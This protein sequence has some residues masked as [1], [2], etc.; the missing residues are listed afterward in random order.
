MNRSFLCLA[1]CRTRSS[2][3]DTLAR[4]SVRHVL[5]WAVFP[6]VP[7]LGSTP[8]ATG[9]PALFGSFPA[10][11]SEEVGLSPF[12]RPLAQTA[13]AVFPQAAFLCGR[14]R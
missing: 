6:V 2:P 7:A 1:A 11:E 14:L 3:C 4:L 5:P 13:R 10:V 9:G 12:L 8:S